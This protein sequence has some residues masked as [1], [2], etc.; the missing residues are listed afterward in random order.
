MLLCPLCGKQ[1]SLRYFDPVGF[2]NDVLVI[3]KR[4]LGRAKGFEE[5]ARYSIIGTNH[6]A[7]NQLRNRV[8]ELVSILDL[9]D[10]IT[11]KRAV[12]AELEAEALSV[13][14]EHE[15]RVRENFEVQFKALQKELEI[16]TRVRENFEVQ[17]KTLRN[18]FND[19]ERTSSTRTGEHMREKNFLINELEAS[20]ARFEELENKCKKLTNERNRL[21][22]DVETLEAKIEEL[23]IQEESD[24]F[25]C[26]V[27]NELCEDIDE[28][29]EEVMWT[30]DPA[31]DDSTKCLKERV[32]YVL[33]EYEAI[34]IGRN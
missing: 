24:C 31:E 10:K 19:L 8:I 3:E 20:E 2:D 13:K 12:K 4:S 23:E 26:P 29:F 11:S 34:I 27:A 14:L 1:N 25:V 7:I 18:D 33:N 6:P 30:L 16:E 9:E 22:V 28:M 5:T 17:Y 21:V 15:M 32:R